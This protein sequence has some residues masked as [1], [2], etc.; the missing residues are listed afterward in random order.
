MA[1]MLQF[2]LAFRSKK[3]R[4]IERGEIAGRIVEEHVF[5]A[6]IRCIDAPI[7]RTGMPLIDR[8][9]VLRAWIGANPGGPSNPVPEIPCLDGFGD[10]AVDS[11]LELPIPVRF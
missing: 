4:E 6:G 2:K 5:R 3:L 9:I 8:R 11:S 7:L 1:E 10:F